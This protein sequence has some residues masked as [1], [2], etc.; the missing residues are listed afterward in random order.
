MDPDTKT[1]QNKVEQSHG[2]MNSL[3]T[4]CP[5]KSLWQKVYGKEFFPLGIRETMIE[6]VINNLIKHNF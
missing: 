5:V 1:F 3:T 4:S 6:N 2:E